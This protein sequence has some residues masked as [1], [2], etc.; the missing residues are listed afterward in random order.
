MWLC[1][2]FVMSVFMYVFVSFGSYLSRSSLRDVF[3]LV[4][5]SFVLKLCICVMCVVVYIFMSF[6]V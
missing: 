1:V 2:H 3:S 5:L 6:V 4:C